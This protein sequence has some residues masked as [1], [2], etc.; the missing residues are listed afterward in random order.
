M[1]KVF[2]PHTQQEC[3]DA[4][5]HICYELQAMVQAHDLDTQAKK[6]VDPQ[7][8]EGAAVMQNCAIE[9]FLLHYRAL[10]TFFNDTDKIKADDIKALDYL[11]T[12]QTSAT[13]VSDKQEGDRI[14]KR[15]AHVSTLRKTLDNDWKL[16]EMEREASRTFEDFISKLAPDQQIWFKDATAVLTQRRPTPLLVTATLGSSSNTMSVTTATVLFPDFPFK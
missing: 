8:K 15:L 6:Q 4:A 14:N 5:P 9:S 3:E 13:W 10:R 7:Y 11:A 1:A 2:P 12:W 16:D